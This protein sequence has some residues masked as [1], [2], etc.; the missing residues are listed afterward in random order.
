MP[1]YDA[2]MTTN[3]PSDQ[4][5]QQVRKRLER[6]IRS[7]RARIQV[8]R[9]AAAVRAVAAS[10]FHRHLKDKKA[11]RLRD[12]TRS[13]QL[14]GKGATPE[15]LGY[16]DIPDYGILGLEAHG[17]LYA[18]W[19]AEAA[20][21]SEARDRGELLRHIF[22]CPKRLDWCVKEGARICREF[23][24]A[25]DEE[26]TRKFQE[27]QAKGASKEWRKEEV[28]EHQIYEME[29]ISKRLDISIPSGLK[30]GT[31]HDWIAL[32]KANPEYWKMPDRLPPWKL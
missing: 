6:P 5:Y 21:E 10:D 14:F 11:A 12:R 22:S 19:I 31:A 25:A 18:L 7:L 13:Q 27:R 1:D 2:G 32:K 15:K 16:L 4:Y 17:A 20:M 24:K 8:L 29:Y 30:R 9:A 28:T 3:T 26:K 23:S